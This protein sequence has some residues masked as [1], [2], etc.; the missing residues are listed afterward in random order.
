MTA[1][2]ARN[3]ARRPTAGAPGFKVETGRGSA[4]PASSVRRC[5][6][7]AEHVLNTRALGGITLLVRIF[8]RTRV[9]EP[10]SLTT[11]VTTRAS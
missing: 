7:L 9:M 1:N 4:G 10:R 6:W 11:S 2:L 8:A 3:R 5:P